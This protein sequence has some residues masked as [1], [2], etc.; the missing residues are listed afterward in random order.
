[1]RKP[2]YVR[3]EHIMS[4][5]PRPSAG[6]LRRNRSQ[7]WAIRVHRAN[8]YDG[9]VLPPVPD[10]VTGL[11]NAAKDLNFSGSMLT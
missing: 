9:L 5:V 1:M 2:K 6:L 11:R 3:I 4:G 7:P 8:S 10:S